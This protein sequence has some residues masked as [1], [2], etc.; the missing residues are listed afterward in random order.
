[1]SKHKN[2]GKPAV[3]GKS[4]LTPVALKLRRLRFLP[5]DE[6]V[7]LAQDKETPARTK[8]EICK[9]LLEFSYSKPKDERDQNDG[10]QVNIQM[11]MGGGR[12]R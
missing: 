11:N 3:R 8:Y 10:V 1:M 7:A 12:Q 5:I 2:A 4:K 6:L 9:L